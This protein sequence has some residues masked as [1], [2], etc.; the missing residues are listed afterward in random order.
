[1]DSKDRQILIE[2]QRDGRLTHQQLAERVNLSPS[3]CSRRVRLLEEAGYIQGY[4]ARVDQKRM[5][6]PITVFVRIKLER[7]TDQ[8]VRDFER[9]IAD[10]APVMDCWLMTGQWDYLLRLVSPDLDEYEHFVRQKLQ[11]LPAIA[12]I[13]TSFAYGEIKRSQILPI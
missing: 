6:L 5:G 13:D 7:H 1:M 4:T 8:T 10:L 12:S 9:A 11:R 3:P 2:L